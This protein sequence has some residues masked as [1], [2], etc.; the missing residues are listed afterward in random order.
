MSISNAQ[1][2]LDYIAG[3]KTAIKD[4]IVAKGV[5]VGEDVTFREYATKIGEIISPSLDGGVTF[6]GATI[7]LTYKDNTHTAEN[8][9]QYKSASHNITI[10]GLDGRATIIGNGSKNVTVTFDVTGATS[11]L[12]NFTITCVK[13]TET[14]VYNGMHAHYGTTVTG[15]LTFAYTNVPKD[16]S[17]G[18]IGVEYLFIETNAATL[19]LFVNATTPWQG[20]Y[21]YQTLNVLL[22]NY[23]STS[24]GTG[25][26]NSCFS[27]NQPLDLSGVT[28]IGTGFLQGCYSFNQP[29]DL[30]GVTSIGNDFMERCDSFNQ[31]L[32]IPSGFTTIGT[33]FMYNAYSFSTIIWDA[34]VYPTDDDAL[35]QTVNSKTNETNGSGI[36]VYGTNRAGLMAALPNRTISPF[37]KLIDG[38]S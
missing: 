24:I 17:E 6:T 28:S 5:E 4:A 19:P 32:T 15:I 21:S 30:S 8:V 20:I 18:T 29:L 25:F 10:T 13:G 33:D 26:L 35:S 27:F 12:K 16:G 7:P 1:A 36:I 14:V 37:R 38:G 34:A 23:S 9:Y 11:S 22:G 3:T 2:K 31:P